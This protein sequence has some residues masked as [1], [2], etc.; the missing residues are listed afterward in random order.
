MAKLCLGIII[1]CS[2]GFAD[3]D[4]Q[5][6]SALKFLQE[7]K[8]TEAIPLLEAWLNDAEV[9]GIRSPEAHHNLAIAYSQTENW[10]PAVLHLA[11]SASLRSNPLYLSESLRTLTRVQNRLMI[12]DAVSARW[13]YRLGMFLGRGLL[14][15]LGLVGVWLFLFGFLLPPA[16]REMWGG[17]LAL[18]LL[19]AVGLGVRA[20]LPIYA[21]VVAGEAG[22]PLLTEPRGANAKKLVDVPSGTLVSLGGS[23]G[24]Q[25]AINQPFA[26]WLPAAFLRVTD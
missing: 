6:E 15:S 12:Q 10:G 11:E 17:A 5:W 14:I 24:D 21:V 9:K 16:R 22:A 4:P 25:T 2:L 1:L 13:G 19:A 18:V 8:P 3:T 23:D 7:N 26:G 20:Y